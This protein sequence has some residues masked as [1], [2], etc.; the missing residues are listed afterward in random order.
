MQ[1][2]KIDTPINGRFQKLATT[3]SLRCQ[4]YAIKYINMRCT[5]MHLLI[6]KKV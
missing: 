1:L 2:V 5:E 6:V 3:L 4:H